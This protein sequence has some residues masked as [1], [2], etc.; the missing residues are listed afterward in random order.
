M[1]FAVALGTTRAVTEG[2]GKH[3]NAAI[4]IGLVIIVVYIFLQAGA[5]H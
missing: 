5:P 4:A 3:R 1:D 2:S